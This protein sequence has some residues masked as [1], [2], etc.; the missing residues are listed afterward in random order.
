MYECTKLS[1]SLYVCLSVCVSVCM[2][3]FCLYVCLSVCMYVNFAIIEMLTHLK[4]V[5]LGIQMKMAVK[6]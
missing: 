1:V 2:S 6:R 5:D 4:M 3:V